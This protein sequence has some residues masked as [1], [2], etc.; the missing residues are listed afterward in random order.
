M[1]DLVHA[2][3]PLL[4][5]FLATIVFALLI[6]LHLDVRTATGAA[7]LVGVGQVIFQKATH[8]PV[9]RLQWASLFL[10]IVFGTLGILTNDPRFLMIKPTIIYLAVGAVMLKKG[11]MIRYLPANAITLVADLAVR[12]GYVW[13]GLMFVTAAANGVIAWMFPAW[14]PVFVAVVPAASKFA[15]FAIQFTSMKLIG[16]RRHDRLM[17]AAT[18]AGTAALE[19]AQAA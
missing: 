10:V 1:K 14:W 7:L 15:L 6:A 4:S 12:W 13:A 8:R 16:H 18:P 11:W 19:T 5:D 17:M 3:R 2:I 9:E